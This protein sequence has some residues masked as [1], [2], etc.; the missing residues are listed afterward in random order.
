[1]IA[2]GDLVVAVGGAGHAKREVIENAFVEAIA[3]GEAMGGG[4]VDARLAAGVG[5]RNVGR[6]MGLQ[7]HWRGPSGGDEGES[8]T[9]LG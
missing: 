5:E 4:K 3:D 2:E 6:L 9:R 8:L 1:M 7:R